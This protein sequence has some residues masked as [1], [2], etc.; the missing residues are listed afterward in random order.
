MAI[1][2]WQNPGKE[3]NLS[4]WL[5]RSIRVKQTASGGG[6]LC[7]IAPCQESTIG[8][9]CSIPLHWFLQMDPS[10]CASSRRKCLYVCAVRCRQR[11][12]SLWWKT[13][14]SPSLKRS[15]KKNPVQQNISLDY[16]WKRLWWLWSGHWHFDKNGRHSASCHSSDKKL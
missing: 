6:W 4:V 3:M 10:L 9:S 12:C 2:S 5:M 15:K 8:D 7:S 11:G 16:A 14:E 13:Q 1:R